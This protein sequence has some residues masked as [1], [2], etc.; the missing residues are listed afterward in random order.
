MRKKIPLL[1][2]FSLVIVVSAV[3]LFPSF[4]FAAPVQWSGN[5]HYYELINGSGNEVPWE[6]ANTA[7]QGMSYNGSQGYLATITSA[8]E[9]S[10]IAN[11]LGLNFW[12]SYW[13]GGY[14][15]WEPIKPDNSQ[16]VGW[17]WVTGETWSYTNWRSGEPNDYGDAEDGE[18]D[19][20]EFNTN[21][22]NSNWCDMWSANRYYIV[23]YG[24]DFLI[25]VQQWF[26]NQCG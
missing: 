10:F 1:L 25:K 4:L 15:D 23:E 2:A 13:I 6:N 11:S 19:F 26:L 8:E 3:F 22:G 5:G 14:Q 20:L 18:E 9:N 7:A 21:G 12:S 24:G 16:A 17:K